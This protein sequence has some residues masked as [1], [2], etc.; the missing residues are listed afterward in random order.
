MR[1]ALLSAASCSL[2]LGCMTPMTPTQRLADSALEMNTATRFGRMDIALEH[3]AAH[4]R[5][6][7]F[8]KHASWGRGVRIVD[9]EIAGM[10][11]R[12]KD[13]ADVFL[14]VAWQRASEADV[15]LTHVSQRWRDDRG[16]RLASEERKGG[17]YGLLGEPTVVMEP[18]TSQAQ[19]KTHVI[20]SQ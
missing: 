12:E 17:D 19:F 15:R 6:A 9:L 18:P 1:I 3:V 4:A 16:W 5:D 14:S 7:F 8:K 2:A 20:R 13:E 11:M 10:N